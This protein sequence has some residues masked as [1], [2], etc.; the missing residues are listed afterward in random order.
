MKT[1]YLLLIVL[2]S[3][4][5]ISCDDLSSPYPAGKT[6]QSY[7]DTTLIGFWE[8]VKIENFADSNLPVDSPMIAIAPFNKKEYL[9]QFLNI[10]DSGKAH[11]KDMGTYRGFISSIGKH[12][13]A[14]MV[15]IS[16]E[17]NNKTE[18]IIYPFELSGDTLTFYSFYSKKVNQEFHSTC[19][20]RKFLKKNIGN[21]SLYSSI[22]KYKKKY[23]KSLNL[24]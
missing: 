17:I 9:V 11:V 13:V 10:D 20:L 4:F 24:K 1:F 15:M 22:R 18:Y 12:K 21:K 8:P 6:C 23:F 2:S 5:I 19:Q 7:I 3:F 14:N 16:P